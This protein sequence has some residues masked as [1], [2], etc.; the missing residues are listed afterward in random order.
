LPGD[1]RGVAPV[2]SAALC[3][4]FD[5][6]L[7][8]TGPAYPEA[9]V[10]RLYIEARALQQFVSPRVGKDTSAIPMTV[11]RTGPWMCPCVPRGGWGRSIKPRGG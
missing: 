9:S 2:S 6:G 8:D 7:Y 10:S 4:R 5:I 1:T 3:G 11:V